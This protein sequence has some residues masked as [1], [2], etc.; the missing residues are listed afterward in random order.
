MNFT[1]FSNLINYFFLS[2][3]I[4]QREVPNKFFYI[5]IFMSFC[6][7]LE[8]LS[9]GF[10]IPI[11]NFFINEE[12]NFIF[13]KFSIEYNFSLNQLILIVALIFILKNI[14]IYFYNSYQSK[15]V[16][17]LSEKLSKK[18]YSYNLT[19]SLEFFIKGNTSQA[20]RDIF[21]ECYIFSNGVVLNFVKIISDVLILLLFFIFLTFIN[22]KITFIITLILCIFALSYF[23]FIRKKLNLIGH[24]RQFHE[25]QRMK[26]IR[27]GFESF[28]FLKMFNLNEFF[29]KKYNRHNKESHNIFKKERIISVLPKLALEVLVIIIFCS[30]IFFSLFLNINSDN[31]ILE[32]A[33]FALVCLRLLPLF[34]SILYSLQQMQFNYS[35]I[36]NLSE[37]FLQ[38]EKNSLNEN[39]KVIF[40]NVKSFELKN[41]NF[42]YDEKNFILKNINFKL[43]DKGIVQISGESGS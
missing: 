2:K 41:V 16:Y 31:L 5:L 26:F 25:S 22:I 4:V 19:R 17:K 23:L 29:T 13:N 24:Q 11:L 43:P 1:I 14:L 7:I 27:E 21:N 38:N 32:L 33:T 39:K 12:T 36:R 9:I 6:A 28:T 34:N 42:K 10:L 40:K 37:I 30:I 20:I 8:L 15:I 18:I 35:V 3:K